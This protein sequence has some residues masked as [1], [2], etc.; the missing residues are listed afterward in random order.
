MEGL[1]TIIQKADFSITISN[2]GNGET[3]FKAKVIVKKL[4]SKRFLEHLESSLV[5][6]T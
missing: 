3:T 1:L 6:T 2:Q 4:L 5:C